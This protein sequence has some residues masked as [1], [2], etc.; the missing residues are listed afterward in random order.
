MSCEDVEELKQPD[1]HLNPL[2]QRLKKLASPLPVVFALHHFFLLGRRSDFTKGYLAFL[3]LSQESIIVPLMQ[4]LVWYAQLLRTTEGRVEP[5]A[6]L[7]WLL[8]YP[9]LV[10]ELEELNASISSLGES[11]RVAYA[12]IMVEID[13]LEE[14]Q[15]RL[16]ARRTE[17]EAL[18]KQTVAKRHDAK[19]KLK[20]PTVTDRDSVDEC[21]RETTKLIAK[22]G[23][24]TALLHVA[25]EKNGCAMVA[26]ELQKECV[27]AEIDALLVVQYEIKRAIKVVKPL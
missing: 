12:Q 16:V 9:K 25:G 6:N 24:E 18:R 7:V 5:D 1:Q 14:G 3:M 15:K 26:K 20:S 11:K 23:D 22:I 2:D 27:V 21:I 4:C 17:L 8:N 10:N 13:E 19:R